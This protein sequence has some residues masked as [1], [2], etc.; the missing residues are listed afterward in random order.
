MALDGLAPAAPQRLADQAAHR[1]HG[2]RAGVVGVRVHGHRDVADHHRVVQRHADVHV[3]DRLV[4]CPFALAFDLEGMGFGVEHFAFDVPQTIVALEPA[5]FD[6]AGVHGF[7][8]MG[9]GQWQ[10][11]TSADK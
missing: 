2:L 4:G 7:S 10:N 8:G 9:R 5:V 6:L 3:V 1:F 11:G